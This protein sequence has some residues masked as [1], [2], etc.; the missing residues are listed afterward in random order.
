V[1]A[2][3]DTIEKSGPGGVKRVAWAMLRAVRTIIVVCAVWWLAV[4]VF[5]I[6]AYLLPGPDIVLGKLVFLA[7]AAQL[8]RHVAA[9]MI[10]IVL[11]FALGSVAGVMCGWLFDRLPP[12]GRLLSPLILLLQTAPKIAIAPLLLLWLGLGLGPKVALIAIVVFFPVLTGTLAGL[13]AVDPAYRDLARLL[14][15]RAM[16]RFRRIELP[17]A[18]PPVFAGLRIATT[19]AVTAAVVGELIGATFG[20]GYLLSVGQENNDAGVVIASILMLSTVGWA[21]HETVRLVEA[22]M[23]AW[24]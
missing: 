22:R 24:R 21:M 14:G 3:T 18:L 2:G 7:S 23:L 16:M 15:L 13:G 5:R 9:T 11:G 1:T 17:F 19:Q 8:E 4:L 12:V 20:L 10:E 6:P